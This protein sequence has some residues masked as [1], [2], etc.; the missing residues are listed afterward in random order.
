[1]NHDQ[2]YERRVDDLTYPAKLTASVRRLLADKLA[3]LH[4]QHGEASRRLN[5]QS[6][7][8]H[9][10]LPLTDLTCQERGLVEDFTTA[11]ANY[12]EAEKRM[13]AH[14]GTAT[15]ESTCVLV[16]KTDAE[17]A[18]AR[19]EYEA[20]VKELDRTRDQQI[21]DV[22]SVARRLAEAQI[23]KV[24]ARIP[25]ALRNELDA[26]VPPPRQIT[27]EVVEAEVVEG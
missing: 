20:Q 17:V 5:D 18:Q 1:M 13:R 6:H 11:K 22:Q 24:K 16:A 10:E 14:F 8:R 19:R 27:G 9:K 23:A 3:L 15:I 4:Q 7:W 21:A 25:E 2:Y 26:L 12:E